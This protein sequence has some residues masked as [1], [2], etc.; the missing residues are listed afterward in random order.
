[1]KKEGTGRVWAA[2]TSIKTL[3][4]GLLIPGPEIARK[5]RLILRRIGTEGHE[6]GI[7]GYDHV[8]W[9]DHIMPLTGTDGRGNR[10]IIEGV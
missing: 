6:L 7:H 3:M 9:H 5:N 10:Q 4:Y 8:Y 1:L 2:A